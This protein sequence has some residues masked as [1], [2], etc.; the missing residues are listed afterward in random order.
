[1]KGSTDS[2]ARARFD[3]FEVDLRT[4]DVRKGGRRIRLQEKSFQILCLLLE[5]AGEVVT[6]EDLKQR[7][8]PGEPFIHFE[9]NLNTNLNR[10]R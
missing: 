1:M 10:L 9:E 7:L 8:W 3:D 5:R 2:S 4:A 6:R